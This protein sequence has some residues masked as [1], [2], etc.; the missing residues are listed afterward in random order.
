MLKVKSIYQALQCCAFLGKGKAA[1]IETEFSEMLKM[2]GRKDD[3]RR[4]EKSRTDK[5]L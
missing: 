4:G 2:A 3:E 5:D 1:D